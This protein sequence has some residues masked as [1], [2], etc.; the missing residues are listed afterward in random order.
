[1]RWREAAAVVFILTLDA[2]APVRPWERGTLL[3][4]CMQP[5]APDEAAWETHVHENREA[6]HGARQV[7][8]PGCGCN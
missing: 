4:S 5:A 8:G 2:C 3:R 7:G 6:A 1:M